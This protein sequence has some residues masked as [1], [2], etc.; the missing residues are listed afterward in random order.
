MR[1]A[2]VHKRLV[3]VARRFAAETA[4]ATLVEFSLVLAVFLL[5]VFGLIDFGRMG[6]TYVMGEKATQMAAR[7]AVVRPPLPA[8]ACDEEVV[9]SRHLRPASPG[10]NPPDFGTMCRDESAPCDTVVVE[11]RWTEVVDCEGDP[12]NTAEEVF[13]RVRSL[14]P[15]GATPANLQFNYRS[16][17][18]DPNLGRQLGFLGGPFT[19]VVTVELVNMRFDFVSPLA[20]LAGLAGATNV[21]GLGDGFELPPMSV[22]LPAED[23]AHGPSQ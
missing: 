9:P 10:P 2:G 15:P 23:L 16:D 7:I 18:S 20:A 5:L 12:G 22:S 14:L 13:C 17:S 1:R 19:P 6:Y 4:G 11:C 3:R 8:S 21:D